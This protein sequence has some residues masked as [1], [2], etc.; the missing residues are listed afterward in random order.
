MENTKLVG[1]LGPQK[2]QTFNMMWKHSSLLKN[3]CSIIEFIVS[4]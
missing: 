4:H 2:C 1:R 3:V